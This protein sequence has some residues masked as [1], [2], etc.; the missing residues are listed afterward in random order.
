MFFAG[1]ALAAALPACASQS[2]SLQRYRAALGKPWQHSYRLTGH[3]GDHRD[4]GYLSARELRLIRWDGPLVQ[5]WADRPSAATHTFWNGFVG[6]AAPW[7]KELRL[8]VDEILTG[9]IAA[10]RP[11]GATCRRRAGRNYSVLTFMIG[12]GIRVDLSLDPSTEL[13]SDAIVASGLAQIPLSNVHYTHVDG[14]VV[15]ISWSDGDNRYAFTTIAHDATLVTILPR[16]PPSIGAAARVGLV[17]NPRNPASRGVRARIDGKHATLLVDTGNNLTVISAS[18]AARLRLRHVTRQYM[19]VAG[20]I[21]RV[22][23]GV[24]RTLDIGPVHMKNEPVAILPRTYGYDGAI[25][26][27]LF[28]RAD[29][30]FRDDV[31]TLSPYIVPG[32]WYAASR[33][34]VTLDTFDGMPIV[35]ASIGGKETEIVLDSGAAFGALFPAR[36]REVGTKAP[37]QSTRC[38]ISGLSS[39]MSPAMY[40]YTDVLIGTSSLTV[41]ACVTQF[42]ELGP[43]L[44]FPVLGYRAMFGPIRSLGYEAARLTVVPRSYT[45]VL[46]NK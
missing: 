12:D 11:T 14:S 25:G 36:F 44:R 34:I 41:N 31:M 3:D 33:D 20:G 19:L 13:P 29:A 28:A 35:P 2:T 45:Y 18:V 26:L 46:L 10:R 22:A 23:V 30:S 37:A 42:D 1:I 17:R 21:E 32:A 40:R 39:L 6:V 15:P 4:V 43:N 24:A 9:R 5:E 38:A 16:R 8:A 27:A 7:R